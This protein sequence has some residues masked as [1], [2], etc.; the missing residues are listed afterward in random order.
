M[1]G[2]G[3]RRVTARGNAINY[4][5]ASVDNRGSRTALNTSVRIF[6]A[7]RLPG[8]GLPPWNDPAWAEILEDQPGN[9]GPRNVPSGASVSFGPF[10]WTD[11]KKRRNYALLAVATCAADRSNLDSPPGYPCSYYQ[12]EIIA[13]VIGDNNVGL[14]YV[15]AN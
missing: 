9:G 4:V 7:R 13:N 1:G 3:P 14:A 11:A 15:R 10:R 5:Y 2:S 8:G 12:S 6:R